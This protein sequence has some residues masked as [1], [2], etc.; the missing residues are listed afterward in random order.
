MDN[1]LSCVHARKAC[2]EDNI[3]CSYYY[4]MYGMDYQEI[5]EHLD[6]DTINTGW[7][8][9]K[10]YP[11]DESTKTIDSGIITNSLALF[12][13]DFVCNNYKRRSN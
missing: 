2:A 12:K 13:K 5:M 11:N 9:L 1:C 8:Y 4:T 10:K 3:V 7:G 6:L